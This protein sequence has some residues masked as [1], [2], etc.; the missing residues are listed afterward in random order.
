MRE[1][2]V[3]RVLRADVGERGRDRTLAGTSHGEDVHTDV[4]DDRADRALGTTWTETSAWTTFARPRWRLH[5]RAMVE[6]GQPD[7]ACDMSA[8]VVRVHDGHM[9]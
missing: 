1:H 7:D 4:D 5:N 8:T 6:D 3:Q 9:G 2:V